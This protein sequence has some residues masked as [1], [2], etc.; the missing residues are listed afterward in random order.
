MSDL[1][2]M[3]IFSS[4]PLAPEDIN[5]HTALRDTLS[6]FQ[7]Q[8]MRE[9]KS[10]H[11]IKAFTADLNLLGSY[12]GDE[13]PLGDFTTSKLNDFLNWLENGRGVPCSRKS[14]ARRVTTLKVFFKWLHS[15]GALGYDPAK[16]VLQRS[17]PAPLSEVLSPRQVEAALAYTERERHARKPDA[18]PALLFRLLLETGIKKSET[19]RLTPEDFNRNNPQRPILNVR[20]KGAKGVY[21]E[22]RIV[23]PPDILPLLDEYLAQWKP[24]DVIFDCTARNLEYVLEDVGRGAG[25]PFKLSFEIMRWTCAVRDYRA[26]VEPTDIRDKLGLSAVSWSETFS[27]VKKLTERQMQQELAEAAAAGLDQSSS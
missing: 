17:G 25:I 18:R 11:T 12:L 2:Q 10:E 15:I 24:K 3:P 26:E 22:R 6:F 9:G 20:H 19:M 16:P 1:R 13:T 4:Q 14:Y 23:L 8:L 5:R 21:K 27:K 7:A